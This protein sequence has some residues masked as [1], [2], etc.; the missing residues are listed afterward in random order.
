MGTRV[1][2]VIVIGLIIA[3]ASI[4]KVEQW[5]QAILLKF[6]EIV[7]SD[8]DPGLHFLVPLVNTAAKYE[9]R[10]LNLDRAPERFITSEKKDLIVDYYA[11]WRIIDV[12]KFY[13]TTQGGD[14]E[15]ANGLLGQ[16]INQALRDEFGKRTVQ[17]VVAGEREEILIIVRDISEDMIKRYGIEVVDVRTKRIDLP[18]EVSSKVYDRM[19]SERVRVAKELR[20]EG[21]EAAERIQANADRERQVI[22]A[23][24]YREAETI[25]GEG[26]AQATEI[27]A[28]AFG[29]DEEFYALYRSLNAYQNSFNN[30]DNVL[31]LEPDSEFFKYFDNQ[32]GR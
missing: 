3:S 5:Q 18:G 12:E 1:L 11:K 13:T 25:R 29:K 4:F 27:Y 31:L 9:T 22:L 6:G 19:R 2:F 28:A 26:D 20:A 16:S 10:I 32:L 17:E 15:Y 8:Y 7:R 21:A 23:N 30:S 14:V 24:A